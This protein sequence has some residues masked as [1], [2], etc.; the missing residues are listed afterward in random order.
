MAK[1]SP[2]TPE[3]YKTWRDYVLMKVR[4]TSFY[5]VLDN[6]APAKTIAYPATDGWERMRD[7]VGSDD[8]W[9]LGLRAFARR[10]SEQP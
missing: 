2:P 8:G 6:L 1:L 9:L 4:Q 3:K 7:A 10:L 5:D